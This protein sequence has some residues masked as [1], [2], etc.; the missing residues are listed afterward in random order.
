MKRNDVLL[1][2]TLVT[3][4]PCGAAAQSLRRYA[5]KPL[6]LKIFET[7]ELHDAP[8]AVGGCWKGA[9]SPA[10]DLLSMK[11]V[12]SATIKDLRFYLTQYLEKQNTVPLKPLA[13]ENWQVLPLDWA[14]AGR[15][16]DQRCCILQPR[17]PFDR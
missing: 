6:V 4:Y 10:E 16:L 14:T 8:R 15:A 17:K 1:A 5:D 3:L 11:Y 9:K 13:F 2:A 7:S 12:T